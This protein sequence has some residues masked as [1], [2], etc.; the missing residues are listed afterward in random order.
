MTAVWRI[1]S[2]PGTN[3]EGNNGSTPGVYQTP[4]PV[5]LPTSRVSASR[6]ACLGDRY[7]VLK[8]LI[9]VHLTSPSVLSASFSPS[10]GPLVHAP[11]FPEAHGLAVRSHRQSGT[12]LNFVALITFIAS[13]TPAAL[14]VKDWGGGCTMAKLK[15]GR[16]FRGQAAWPYSPQAGRDGVA[17]G[18]YL[19]PTKRKPPSKVRFFHPDRTGIINQP[20]PDPPFEPEYTLI[21]RSEKKLWRRRAKKT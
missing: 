21:K 4:S 19:A 16:K 20:N 8:G 14:C 18:K 7:G 9:N 5:R 6:R 12:I 2:V 1:P 13:S 17:P 11:R 15:W 10:S 3:P